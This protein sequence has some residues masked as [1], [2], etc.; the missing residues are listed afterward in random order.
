MCSNILVI[1]DE[2][3]ILE[4]IKFNLE[5]NNHKV[6]TAENGKE[7]IEKINELEIDLIILD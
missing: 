6:Y 5:L 4:L 1:D 3:N 7:G 2:L